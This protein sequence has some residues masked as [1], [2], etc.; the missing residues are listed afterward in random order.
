VEKAYLTRF[1]YSLLVLGSFIYAFTAMNVLLIATF[2]API[3]A[4][5]G[6]TQQILI[7]GLLLSTGKLRVTFADNKINL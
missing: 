7:S 5:F 6:L 3:I 2:L 1:H 4:E